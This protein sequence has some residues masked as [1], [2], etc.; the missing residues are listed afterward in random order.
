MKSKSRAYIY[1]GRKLN[2]SSV[3]TEITLDAV[4]NGEVQHWFCFSDN[5]CSLVFAL[6][7]Y[8]YVFCVASNNT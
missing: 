5:D 6:T 1:I 4:M 8:N 7:M 3:K 2:E